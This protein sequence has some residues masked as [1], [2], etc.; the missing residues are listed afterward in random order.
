MS[1]LNC[2]S[3]CLSA[4]MLAAERGR[5]NGKEGKMRVGNVSIGGIREVRRGD[6]HTHTHTYIGRGWTL[7][8]TE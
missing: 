5:L 6:T 3:V 7:I 2:L 8:E 4:G 1:P